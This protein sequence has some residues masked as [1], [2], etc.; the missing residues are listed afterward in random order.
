MPRNTLVVVI[1]LAIF[2]ALVVGVNI[3]KGNSSSQVSLIPS[4]TPNELI[5]SP[6]VTPKLFLYTNT[7]CGLSFQYPETL[8][9]MD[10]G[11]ASSSA[12]FNDNSSDSSIIVLCGASVPLES[13]DSLEAIPITIPLQGSDTAS[14]SGKMYIESSSASS[15]SQLTHIVIPKLPNKM[16]LIISIKGSIIEQILSSLQILQMKP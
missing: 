10:A 11:I 14:V 1:V 2:A 5:P 3:G 9:R 12:V 8:K 4:P 16:E 7:Y 15:S 6:T 13:I